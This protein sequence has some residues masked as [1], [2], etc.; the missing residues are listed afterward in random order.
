MAYRLLTHA[1]L[2]ARLGKLVLVTTSGDIPRVGTERT[3]KSGFSPAQLI[4]LR[5]QGTFNSTEL[6]EALRADVAQLRAS[7]LPWLVGHP[8]IVGEFSWLLQ[9]LTFDDRRWFLRDYAEPALSYLKSTSIDYE[10]LLGEHEG[11]RLQIRRGRVGSVSR[12]GDGFEVALAH[13]A[14]E[15]ADV[16]VNCLG[17]ADLRITESPLLAKLLARGLVR[18]NEVGRGLAL[19][20]SF[21]ASPGLYVLGPLISGLCN[22]KYTCMRLESITGTLWYASQVAAAIAR[23]SR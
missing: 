4:E 5:A 14:S 17:T 18:M 15:R 9:S 22:A 7:G 10:Q 1:A 2:E 21:R 23:S 13:G 16:I 6:F 19:D 11:S 20:E 8:A 12:T 3:S